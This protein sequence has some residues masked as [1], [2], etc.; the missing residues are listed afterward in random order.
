MRVSVNLRSHWD[1]PDRAEGVT[2]QFQENK[3]QKNG[4]A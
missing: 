4:T 1:F 2:K 3:K